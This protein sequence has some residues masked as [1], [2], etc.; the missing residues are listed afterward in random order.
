MKLLAAI[1]FSE[2]TEPVVKEASRLAEALQAEL[3]LLHVRPPVSPALDLYP[4]TEIVTLPAGGD[5]LPDG[6]LPTD[7]DRLQDIAEPLRA[8]GIPTTAITIAGDEVESIISEHLKNNADMIVMGSHGHGALFHLLVGSVSEGVVRRARCP[9]LIV[10]A[11][12]R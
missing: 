9:V 12:I 6:A 8:M 1:D 11:A 4:E 2:L 5:P 3:I 7:G 10:P